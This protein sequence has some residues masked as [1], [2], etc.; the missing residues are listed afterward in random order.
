MSILVAGEGLVFHCRL[1]GRCRRD[2]S[3]F[4]ENE[5]KHGNVPTHELMLLFLSALELQV[6]K[7][8]DDSCSC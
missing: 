1:I 2:S 7:L 3:E 4:T 5:A 8:S 6:M